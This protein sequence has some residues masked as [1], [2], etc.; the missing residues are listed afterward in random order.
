MDSIQNPFSPGVGYTPS[1]LVGRDQVLRQAQILFGRV[2][3]G[4][5]EKSL[6]LTGRRGVGKTVLLNLD[7]A[8]GRAKSNCWRTL[9]CRTRV[10]A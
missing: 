8:L 7:S 10:S 3:H 2:Q 1:D 9:K 5:S 4:K 6:L